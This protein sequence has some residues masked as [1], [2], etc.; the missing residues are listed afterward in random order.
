MC[1]CTPELRVPVCPKCHAATPTKKVFDI[2]TVTDAYG[3]LVKYEVIPY[4]VL[5]E[6]IK[7]GCTLPTVTLRDPRTNRVFD[8]SLENYS[9]SA[10]EAWDAIK[11][12]LASEIMD[13]ES[14]IDSLQ[15]RLKALLAYQYR[16]NSLEEYKD[17]SGI[18]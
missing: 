7:E 5:R 1:K 9:E 18:S 11:L 4:L 13:L 16:L 17:T 8:S 3:N 2:E 14:D 10:E 6:G 12:D 15:L